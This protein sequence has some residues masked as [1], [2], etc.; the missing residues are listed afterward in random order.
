MSD[1]PRVNVKRTKPNE[2]AVEVVGESYT[3]LDPVA[4]IL[5][6]LDGIEFAGY[7][8]PHPLEDRGILYVRVQEGDPVDTILE[9]IGLLKEEYS[10]LRSSLLEELTRVKAE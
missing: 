5:H 10:E 9:A 3:L 6:G 2:V 8:V 1:E 7:D 4:H